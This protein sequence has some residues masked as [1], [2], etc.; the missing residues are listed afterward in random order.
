[1]TLGERIRYYRGLIG[2]TQKQL[3][4]DVGFKKSTAD[5]RIN[6]YET[7]K[8]APKADLRQKLAEALD[9]DISA[10]SDINIRSAEDI[11]RVLFEFEEKLDMSIERTAKKTIL[12]FDNNDLKSKD[13]NLDSYFYAW[14]IQKK[15]L[16]P[17]S[18]DDPASYD[19]FTRYR[20]WKA[21]FPQDINSYLIEEEN[22]LQKLYAPIKA[23][24]AEKHAPIT[25][26]SEFLL[27][28]R[29]LYQ[30]GLCIDLHTRH[31]GVGDGALVMSFPIYMLV[32]AATDSVK[33]AFSIYLCD[34]DTLGSYGMPWHTELSL[35]ENGSI[36]SYMLRW[37]VLTAF[38]NMMNNMREFEINKSTMAE[39]AKKSYE[40]TLEYELKQYELDLKK[41]FS[42]ATGKSNS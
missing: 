40:E 3:G 20:K 35:D 8:M 34:I 22:R 23:E 18:A 6:Q 27:D 38:T 28:I 14:Y 10:L 9:V 42:F 32:D 16:P 37:S 7:N 17:K 19:T 41:E 11:L 1:M 21:R 36:I 39:Y 26:F 24:E 15:N 4:E 33:E 30:S 13:S 25:R 5:V 12:T 29:K 2:K 31:L